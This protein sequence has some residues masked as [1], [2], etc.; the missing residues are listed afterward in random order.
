MKRLRIRHHSIYQYAQAV[1]LGPHRLMLRPRDSHVSRLI[2]ARLSVSPD[3][4]L[5]WEY[6]VFGNSVAIA[7][8]VAATRRLEIDSTILI[9]HYGMAADI[10]DLDAAARAVPLVY[11]A[12]E[13]P[14][15]APYVT[16][17]YPDPERQVEEWARSFLAGASS[18]ETLAVLHDLTRAIGGG[19]RYAMRFDAGTQPPAT[20]LAAR[21]G[22]CRDFAVLMM[23][24]VRCLGLAARFVSG[25]LNS[26]SAAGSAT[27][28]YPHAWIEVYLPGA[29]WIEF[30][31]TNGLAGSDRLIRVA[32]S[33]DAEQAMPVRGSYVGLP[34]ACIDTIVQVEI[35]ELP[36]VGP[37]ASVTPAPAKA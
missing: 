19:F 22:T 25:Y 31:P 13:A 34:G 32:V 21:G 33:R 3:A 9:D 37:S 26:P 28:G 12:A 35:E 36:L 10:A 14:D 30:D 24:A 11:P 16:R 8:F 1:T 5:R 7:R 18:R 27:L 6:D 15:L 2:D 17:H 23:E 29:G 4:G 20:T